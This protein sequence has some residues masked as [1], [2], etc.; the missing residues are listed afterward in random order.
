MNSIL[1]KLRDAVGQA[2]AHDVI[3]TA[4]AAAY[5]GMLMLFPA[6][7]VITTILAQVPVGTTLADEFRATFVQF[8]PAD[9]FDLLQT[10]VLT[11]RIHSGQV[12]L[13]A[14]SLSILAGLGMMLSLMEGFRRAYRIPRTAWGFWRRRFRALLLVPLALVPLSMA[15]LVVVFG[16]QIESWMI[17][18]ANH[19]LRHIVLVF[20]RL[21]RWLVALLTS[22][23]VLTALYHFG[24]KR[25]EHWRHVFPG[26]ITATLL[27]FPATL[28][29]GWYV[30]SIADYTMFYGSFG[31]GIATLV[32][33]YITA[34]SVLI[35]AELNGALFLNR[36]A[37][38]E[39]SGQI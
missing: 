33:L 7:L 39:A 20:W 36:L 3:N 23:S 11:R 17:E 5:S 32:W 9:T 27:W 31:A 13:S 25:N 34:F 21:V 12:I 22:V 8:L 26:A 19:E 6:V 29:F 18:N 38:S 14:T 4:K 28:A 10:Y 1:A 24:T 16:H 2:L 37:K 30:T 15:T 35:G